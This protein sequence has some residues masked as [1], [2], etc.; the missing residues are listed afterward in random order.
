LPGIPTAGAVPSN[1]PVA[2]SGS[3]TANSV[4]SDANLA[5]LLAVPTKRNS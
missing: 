4:P 2:S 1:S 5:S 3:T